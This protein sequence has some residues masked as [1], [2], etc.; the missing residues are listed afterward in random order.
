MMVQVED[1][2]CPTVVDANDAVAHCF[3]STGRTLS[4]S[5]TFIR[6]CAMVND[7]TPNL[8]AIASVAALRSEDRATRE[9]PMLAFAS[10]LR[11]IYGGRVNTITK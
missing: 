5:C 4:S 7:T 6:P 9:A 11:V 2:S 1:R 8:A 10:F 3:V